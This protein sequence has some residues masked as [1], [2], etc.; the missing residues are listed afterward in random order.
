MFYVVGFCPVYYR[1][2]DSTGRRTRNVISDCGFFYKF[3][4]PNP[5]SEIPNQKMSLQYEKEVEETAPPA[6]NS[7]NVQRAK[8]IFPLYSAVLIACLV[9]VSIFQFI[10]DGK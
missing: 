4:I 3:S 2:S 7:E 6:E 9:A 8:L 1:S 5:Q 10:V